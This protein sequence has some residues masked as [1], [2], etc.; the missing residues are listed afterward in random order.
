MT[1][2]RPVY[3][4]PRQRQAMHRHPEAR[5]ILFLDGEM[6]ESTF[7]GAHRFKPGEF[8]FRPTHFAHADAAGSGGAAYVRLPVSASAARRWFARY[9]WQAA[10]GHADPH[11]DMIGDELL[12]QASPRT[13]AAGA[14]QSPMQWAAAWLASNAPLRVQDVAARLKLEPYELTRRFAAAT[15]LAP[16]AYRRQARLQRAIKLVCEDGARLAEIAAEAGF[17]DQS[18]L[19]AELKRETGLTPRALRRAQSAR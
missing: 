7:G 6:E 9:G 4:L 14:P 1:A 11:R 3:T 19:T 10:R 16:N 2:P 5:L 17:H 15:G 18:H 13:Y 12:E 8:V